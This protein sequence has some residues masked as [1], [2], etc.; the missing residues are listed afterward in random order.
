[1]A[2]REVL[3]M[4]GMEVGGSGGSLL[5]APGPP[6]S[7]PGPPLAWKQTRICHINHPA[8]PTTTPL[9]DFA[10]KIVFWAPKDLVLEAAGKEVLYLCF[11]WFCQLV[12]P[13]KLDFAC[14]LLVFSFVLLENG[15]MCNFH[16][17]HPFLFSKKCPSQ[18]TQQNSTKFNGNSTPAGWQNST[19]PSGH[20]D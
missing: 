12:C 18:K 2:I 16:L 17:S 1:M 13:A 11:F 8:P 7:F 9:R 19:H 3:G 6:W 20:H 4:G 15:K 5:L 14:I 10:W